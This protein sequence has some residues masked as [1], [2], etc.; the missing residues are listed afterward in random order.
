MKTPRVLGLTSRVFAVLTLTIPALLLPVASSSGLPAFAP[1]AIFRPKTGKDRPGLETQQSRALPGSFTGPGAM[2]S[3]LQRNTARPVS[4]VTADLN[5]DGAGDLIAGYAVGDRGLLEIYR[6]NFRCRFPNGPEAWRQIV[7][8]EF[9]EP[10]FLSSVAVHE[11]PEIPEL[12]ATGDFTGDGKLDVVTGRLGSDRLFLLSGSGMELSPATAI[13]LPGK[14][15]SLAASPRPRMGLAVGLASLNGPE[16]LVWAGHRKTISQSP[17]RYPVPAD[18]RGLAI[19]WLDQDLLMDVVVAAGDHLVVLSGVDRVGP[20]VPAPAD[21]SQQSLPFESTALV[22]GQFIWDRENRVELAVLDEAGLLHLLSQAGLDTRPWTENELKAR[23]EQRRFLRSGMMIH[24]GSVAGM[25]VSSQGESRE[26]TRSLTFMLDAVP[27]YAVGPGTALGAARWS[28]TATDDVLVIQPHRGQLQI[29]GI[30][31]GADQSSSS[32]NTKAR[33]SGMF[34][35]RDTQSRA[36]VA[37]VAL[38]VNYDAAPD[39]V[40]LDPDASTPSLK[41]A[42]GAAII[43][44]NDDHDNLVPGN[45]KCTLREAIR[46]ANANMD[47]TMGDCAP[48]MGADTIMVPAGFFTLEIM[49]ADENAAATGDLDITESLTVMGA[50]NA[51][52]FI[53]GAFLYPSDPL[54]AIDRVFDVPSGNPNVT[55]DGVRV[56]YGRTLSSFT[57]VDGGGIHFTGSGTLTLAN[58]IVDSNISAGDGGGVH[59]AGSGTVMV[60]NSKVSLNIGD[61]GGGIF[62]DTGTITI[63]N[64]SSIF[65]NP[66]SVAGGGVY[67]GNGTVTVTNSTMKENSTSS[68][69]GGALYND[70]S[71]TVTHSILEDNT[72]DGSGG[73]AFN[74]G[75]LDVI[76]STVKGNHTLSGLGGGIGTDTGGTTHVSFTTVTENSGS[77]IGQANGIVTVTQSL[78]TANSG[79]HG[80]GIALTGGMM[81]VSNTTIA[82]NFSTFGGALDVSGGSIAMTNCTLADNRGSALADGIFKS[83]GSVTLTNCIMDNVFIQNN[84][85]LVNP[86]TSGGHNIFSDDSCGPAVMGDQVNTDPKLFSLADNGGPTWTQALMSDSPALDA[87]DATAC[88]TA[89]VSNQDQRG[90]LRPTD[91]DGDGTA[92]CDIGAFEA[93]ACTSDHTPPVINCATLTLQAGA[94]CQ[95]QIPDFTS[96][97]TD[98][99][100]QTP[101]VVQMPV[102]GTNAGLGSIVVT[103]NAVDDAGNMSSCMKT[104]MVIN[105]PPVANAGPDQNVDEGATVVLNGTGSTDPNP[106]QTLTYAWMQMGGPPVTLTGAAT[107]TPTFPAP[108]IAD[109]SCVSFTF[110]LKV[111][112]SCGATAT[113]TVVINVSDTFVLQGDSGGHCVVIRRSCGMGNAGTYCWRKPN[114]TTVSGPCTITVQGNTA[115]FQSTQADPLVF[116]AGADLGRKVGNARLTETRALPATTSIIV[117]SNI[118]NSACLCP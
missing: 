114:S 4:L 99:C 78:L 3:A 93:P 59:N 23:S 13:T 80:G 75:V 102:A 19:E 90:F 84:C 61:N 10:A 65:H 71:A 68:G 66:T 83:M 60:T 56:Q 34:R 42:S 45:M 50:G 113:D 118:S 54:D 86:I 38:P 81:T 33:R 108:E 21:M 7:T 98:A 107:A 89:P 79:G 117:D 52:T 51:N 96:S 37:A 30:E 115:N 111:T 72:A 105:N 95:A 22:T 53:E 63:V 91:G 11:L 101:T 73:G 94:N 47:L 15:T 70:A 41:L 49:G 112:D 2:V 97:V 24:P 43:T 74:I 18:P 28:N 62:N 8:G 57:S 12:V 88:S 109:L 64:N 9:D 110:Q 55:L 26:T 5:A 48:G 20:P 27:A 106:G 25:P 92:H 77:G 76:N 40:F 67:N 100:D 16:V 31:A 87:G 104:V 6:G 36:V 39:L 1:G 82:M 103:I 58:S 85:F 32:G 46:N 17:D 29:L 116:Q 69:E 35:I 44:V 14:L